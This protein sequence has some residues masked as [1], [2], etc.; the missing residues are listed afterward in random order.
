MVLEHTMQGFYGSPEHGGNLNDASW[1]MLDIEH[2]MGGH[3][4]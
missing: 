1:K 3:S 2:V 4:H